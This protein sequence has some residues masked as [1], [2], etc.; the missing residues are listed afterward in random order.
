[1]S[2]II[3]KIDLCDLRLM[4][5]RGREH[6]LAEFQIEKCEGRLADLYAI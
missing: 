5:A 6:F 4:G 2:N 3:E 1:L